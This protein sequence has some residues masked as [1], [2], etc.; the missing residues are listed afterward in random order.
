M[1]LGWLQSAPF[2]RIHPVKRRHGSHMSEMSDLAKLP[3]ANAQHTAFRET[4]GSAEASR[5]DPEIEFVS[6][7]GEREIAIVMLSPGWQRC[8]PVHDKA[9]LHG[10]YMSM[11]IPGVVVDFC[12][13]HQPKRRWE[14]FQ[15][16]VVAAPYVGVR[17]G[18]SSA[19]DPGP[20]ASDASLRTIKRHERQMD[21]ISPRTSLMDQAEATPAGKSG[22]IPR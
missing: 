18:V 21:F 5:P 6:A 4:A 11:F 20:Y 3:A 8:Q 9:A 22:R 1:A 16:P 10:Q 14:V 19:Q 13:V 2:R 7:L 15:A 12:D 17:N